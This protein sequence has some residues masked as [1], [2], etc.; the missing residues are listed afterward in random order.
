MERKK[1][2]KNEKKNKMKRKKVTYCP[3]NTTTPKEQLKTLALS[4][5][6]LR[7]VQKRAVLFC[8]PHQQFFTHSY[9]LTVCKISLISLIRKDFKQKGRR[10]SIC[11]CQNHHQVSLHRN[12][13]TGRRAEQRRTRTEV[14]LFPSLCT[15]RS[16]KTNSLNQ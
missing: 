13:S 14:L 15:Y 3:A 1:E 10:R 4:T 11:D 6:G 12:I 5:H 2:E 16:A 8:Q 7:L 9:C